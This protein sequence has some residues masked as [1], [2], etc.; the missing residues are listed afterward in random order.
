MC[1]LQAVTELH[2]YVEFKPINELRAQIG[3]LKFWLVG[4]EHASQN[5]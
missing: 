1:H 3:T 4:V 5:S 2:I